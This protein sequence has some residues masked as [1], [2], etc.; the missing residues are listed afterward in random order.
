LG[1][2]PHPSS[3]G[4]PTFAS[5][6]FNEANT[7][8][9]IAKLEAL[10]LEIKKINQSVTVQSRGCDFQQIASQIYSARRATD[11]LFGHAGFSAS[12]AWD[13]VTDLYRLEAEGK[14]A[15]VSS[16]CIGAAC[17]PTTALRWLQ[18][19]EDMELV[20]RSEDPKDK[21]RIYVSLTPKGRASTVSALEAHSLQQPA[22]LTSAIRT[23]SNPGSI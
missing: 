8:A 19:L 23:D 21:R 13:I 22:S 5:I 7:S 6:G 12:P 11:T 14:R 4:S 1:I 3:P 18:L 16:A 9:Y 2:L 10:I 17:P 15:S 20:S